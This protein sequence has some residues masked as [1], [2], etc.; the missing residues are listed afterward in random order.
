MLSAYFV[1]GYLIGHWI[2][3]VGRVATAPATDAMLVSLAKN[4]NT[5]FDID[6]DSQQE[7]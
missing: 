6:F 4:I 7:F 3:Q 5:N 1:N 2:A